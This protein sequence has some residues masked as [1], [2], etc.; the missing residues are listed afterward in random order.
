MSGQL[1][2]EYLADHPER[3]SELREWFEREWGAY[4]GPGGPGDAASDLLRYSNR[5]GL[6]VGLIALRGEE[7]CGIAALKPESISTHP[8]L[9]PWAAAGL[10]RREYRRQGI[11][12]RLL[13]GLEGVAR[14]RGYEH[15]YCGTATAGTLLIRSGWEFMERLEYH[16]DDLAI[17]RKGLL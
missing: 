9:A 2:I 3:L 5:S 8:H 10:V 15:I 14:D 7:L 4:Y 17:Y 13:S 16:G 12:A 6:P 11:G 1:R